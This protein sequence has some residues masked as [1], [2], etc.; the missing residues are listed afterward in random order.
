MSFLLLMGSTLFAAAQTSATYHPD[1]VDVI[2][3][4]IENNGLIGVSKDDPE[5]WGSVVKWNE[6]TPKR[7]YTMSLSYQGLTGDILLSN[8]TGLESLECTAPVELLDVSGL[9]NLHTLWLVNTCALDVSGCTNLVELIY[10][11]GTFSELDLSS[12]TSLQYLAL[13][14]PNL[15]ALDVSNLVNLTNLSCG[16]NN[17]STLDM[18][19]LINLTTLHCGD[20]KLTA[21]DLTNQ[22]SSLTFIGVR[23]RV[24]LTL[25]G[26]DESGYSVAIDLNNP[27]FDN[28]AV[29]YA[30]GIL[31]S[32]DS[33]VGSVDFTV[34]TG[35]QGK[36]LSGIITLTYNNDEGTG[37]E[38]TPA[39]TKTPTGYYTLLGQ[40]LRQE[41][42][43]GMYIILYDDGTSEKVKRY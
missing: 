18:S 31:T 41:P 42:T 24:S 11:Y 2:N 40:K 5:N 22:P 6:E 17:I 12:C 4:L 16:S 20:N 43:E 33:S 30:N 21:L 9:T 3:N 25:S 29:S 1:D 13:S 39:A 15:E 36:L 23:Q 28:E 27:E 26:N 19:N 34:E 7:I 8:L 10:Y 38:E 37:I 14:S 35:L 32:T